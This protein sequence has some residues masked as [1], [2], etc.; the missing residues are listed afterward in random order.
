METSFTRQNYEEAASVIRR[1]AHVEPRIGIILGSG[2]SALAD[3][4]ED[5]VSIEFGAIPHFP[6][7]T[8]AG[9]QGRLVLG[10]LQGKPVA[11]MQGRV[12]YYEGYDMQQV[13][14]PVRV[15]RE[16]GVDTLVVTNAAGGLN[17]AFR[18]GDLMLIVDHINL[19][20][21]TGANPL[22]GPNNSTL[23]PRFPDMSKAYDRDL[24]R[25]AVAVATETGLPLHQGIY[26]GLTGP[27]YETPA[28]IRFLRLI[29]ADAVGMSTVPEVIV[30]R[31]GGMRVLGVSG[32]SNVAIDQV[33]S[34]AE[35]SHEEVLQSGALI[36]P[37]MTTLIKGVLAQL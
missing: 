1:A 9:H 17:Q 25:L 32:I 3:A 27:T 24:R 18:A 7:S 21:M 28:D 2:L 37:R 4:V 22:R 34:D 30:A 19:V 16:L 8:I 23:G 12:H 29:G 33:D 36:T 26:V 5:P 35:A 6:V 13:T 14:L 11:V 20:G 10:W 31:H 15:L